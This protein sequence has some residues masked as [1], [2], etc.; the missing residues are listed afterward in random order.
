[1]DITR[2][3]IE[4][5]CRPGDVIA[6]EYIQRDTTATIIS[7]AEDGGKATHALCCLGGLD[8]VEASISGVIESNLGNYLRGNCRL[9][10]R[11]TINP[12]TPGQQEK[13]C[14]FWLSQVNHKYDWGMV[15]GYVPVIVLKKLVGLFS[16]NLSDQIVH[17]FPNMIANSNLSTCAELAALGLHEF[18]LISFHSYNL[19][20]VTPEILRTDS[21]LITKIVLNAATLVD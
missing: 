2:S 16:K 3:E 5:M 21:S 19:E 18:D 9:T 7:L 10:I 8:I 13:V 12:P 17:K 11:S 20:N 1:M 4:E 14:N 6:V 15:I